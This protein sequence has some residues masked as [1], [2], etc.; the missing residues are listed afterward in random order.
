MSFA[1]D[2][3]DEDMAAL[4]PAPDQLALVPDGQQ[5]KEPRGRARGCG[6]CRSCLFNRS[7]ARLRGVAARLVVCRALRGVWH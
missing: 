4:M 2:D 5:Q 3:G 1:D 6:V 7:K